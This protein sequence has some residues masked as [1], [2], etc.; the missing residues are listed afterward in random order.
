MKIY[1]HPKLN[2]K[3]KPSTSDPFQN[4]KIPT[5]HVWKQPNWVKNDN[6]LVKQNVA[7]NVAISF[8]HF[9][10]TKKSI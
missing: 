9:I 4:L 7:K 8:V 6:N 1:L 3:P 5:S 10:F 2:F